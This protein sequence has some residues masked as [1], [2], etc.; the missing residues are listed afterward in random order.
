MHCWGTHTSS[1]THTQSSTPVPGTRNRG[2]LEQWEDAT[3]WATYYYPAGAFGHPPNA[4]AAL[5][6]LPT[7]LQPIQDPPP[8]S[9][10]RILSSEL[11]QQ[12][13]GCQMRSGSNRAAQPGD[14][15]AF[16]LPLSPSLAR[17]D[18]G[19]VVVRLK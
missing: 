19:E 5:S 15:D 16:P 7:W 11:G 8:D 18:S 13:E 10:E 9:S 6:P 4:S 17:L 2:A 3:T 14:G 12:A 1:H